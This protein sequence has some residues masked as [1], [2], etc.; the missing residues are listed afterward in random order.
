MCQNSLCK[1]AGKVV[2]ISEK[3]RIVLEFRKTDKK[4]EIS[5]IIPAYNRKEILK[6]TLSF[7]FNQTCPSNNYEII[8]VDDGS[9]DN[10]G[11]MIR[12][13][14]PPCNLKYIYW[15]RENAYV[16]G[17]K[18]NRAGPARNIGA[19]FAQADIL[20]FLDS[21]SIAAPELLEEHIRAHSCGNDIVLG[22]R[23]R[24]LE[25]DDNK[26][27]E[28]TDFNDINASG[29]D[30]RQPFFEIYDFDVSSCPT[31]WV[32]FFSHN[33][34]I[35]R[36]HF[37]RA[38]GFC[39]DFVYW[40][41][42]DEE[43]GYRLYKK[44][45]K[46]TLN[47][48]AKTIHQHHA[49]E[50][51][52]EEIRGKGCKENTEIFY[53]KHNDVNIFYRHL[54][55]LHYPMKAGGACNNNCMVCSDIGNKAGFKSAE[56][57]KHLIDKAKKRNLPI[58]L[59]GGEVPIRKDFFEILE[60][61]KKTG[62]EKVRLRTNGRIFSYNQFVKRVLDYGIRDFIIP[63][64]GHTATLHDSMTG[65]SGWNR[66]THTHEKNDGS[67]DQTITGI[68]NLLKS[69]ARVT[70]NVVLI[71]KN[72][73]FFDQIIAY[74]N[75]VGVAHFMITFNPSADT[76]FS[77]TIE[78]IKKK[79]TQT[80]VI[81][82]NPFFDIGNIEEY[83]ENII[84][85]HVI[86][87][88][89]FDLSKLKKPFSIEFDN[90]NAI[91]VED[92]FKALFISPSYQPHWSQGEP[93]GLASL[94]SYLKKYAGVSSSILD[95]NISDMDEEEIIRYVKSY[96]PRLIG[97]TAIT[98][99]VLDAYRIGRMLKKAFPHI[100][101]VYG[102]V[103]PT[104]MP[105]EPFEK[106]D[107]DSIIIGEGEETLLELVRALEKGSSLEGIKG[108]AYRADNDRIVVNEPRPFIQDLSTLPLPEYKML[109]FDK[110]N[111]DIHVT[112]HKREPAAEVM[113]S[114]G[115]TGN[116]V[117]C[118]SPAL[119]KR[120]VRFRP[121]D[122]I[123]EELDLL[124]N[125]MGI[126]AIHFHD[127]NFLLDYKRVIDLCRKIKE[128]KLDFR[129]I[130]LARTDTVV[131]HPEILKDMKNVG[132]VG[133][134]I[135]VE[136]ADENVL[137]KLN[138]SQDISTIRKA[139][140]LLKES[141][142]FPIYLIMCYSLGE[143]IE[144]PYKSA[145]LYYELKSG[146]PAGEELPIEEKREQHDEV[147]ASHMAR[148]SPGAEFYDI[149]SKEG[150]LLC[151]DWN[152]HFEE[153]IN[154]I[155]KEFLNDIPATTSVLKGRNLSEFILKYSTNIQFYAD[156]NFYISRPVISEHFGGMDNYLKF[157]ELVHGCCDGR[158][159]VLE[160]SEHLASNGKKSNITMVS[161][162]VAMLSVLGLVRSIRNAKNSEIDNSIL[163]KQKISESREKYESIKDTLFRSFDITQITDLIKGNMDILGL[164]DGERAYTGPQRIE[165]HPTNKC[166][167][168]CICCWQYSPLIKNEK[169]KQELR[170]HVMPFRKMKETVDEIYRI[171]GTREILVSGG[172][173]PLLYPELF[174]L[175]KYIKSKGFFCSLNT[176]FTLIGKKE[177][178]ML[179]ESG[180]DSITASI[181]AGDART[182]SMLHPN[183][184][185][186][187]FKKIRNSMKFFKKRKVELGISKPRIFTYNVISNMNY[188]EIEAMLEFGMEVGA[189]K[190]MFTIMDSNTPETKCLLLPEKNRK[191]L[192]KICERL[193]ENP[194]YNQIIDWP[195]FS[196]FLRRIS[197]N[198][199][200]EG[201]YEKGFI[202]KI[203]CFTGWLFAEFFA[204]GNVS[205][206]CK[207]DRTP[208]GN[209][210]KNRFSDIWNSSNQGDFR[211]RGLNKQQNGEY[212]TDVIYCDRV[213]D[214][215][216]DINTFMKKIIGTNLKDMVLLNHVN[217]I[218][219]G[220]VLEIRLNESNSRNFPEAV[221][222]FGS[223]G[224]KKINISLRDLRPGLSH[225][226][227]A[228]IKEAMYAAKKNNLE[229]RF[230][231]EKTLLTLLSNFD[232]FCP[233]EVS[234]YIINNCNS[235]CL[236]CWDHSPLLK[237]RSGTWQ[238]AKMDFSFFKK[239]VDELSELGT[240]RINILGDGEPLLHPEIGEMIKYAKSKDL[241]ISIFTNGTMLDN[242]KDTINLVDYLLINVSAAKPETYSEIHTN[243]SSG[244]FEKVIE[245]I[246]RLSGKMRID[247]VN[248]ITK[249]NINEVEEMIKLAG[250]IGAQNVTIKLISSNRVTGETLPIK[251]LLPSKSKIRTLQK[252][253]KKLLDI[254][255]VHGIGL[256]F[257][258]FQDKELC[259]KLDLDKT[260]IKKT[261]CFSRNV[262]IDINGNLFPCAFI[263]LRFGNLKEKKISYF[264]KDFK[265]FFE[266][267]NSQDFEKSPVFGACRKICIFDS[268]QREKFRELSGYLDNWNG[269][270]DA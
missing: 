2:K 29:L 135:G 5:V 214:N 4:P 242:I 247:I 199:A 244:D 102:G 118:A 106:G 252:N 133:V 45:L 164:L 27:L 157:M 92:E 23:K 6:T 154:F 201:K 49:P 225:D 75:A 91:E 220:G 264:K 126:R 155:P 115:C 88:E 47:K 12:S 117:Y 204:D 215:L 153:R 32:F 99:Q 116:C 143:T 211:K 124:V 39:E 186:K 110:Y 178:E 35:K 137:R 257:Q 127:D 113:T 166:N 150:I 131:Q 175:L 146:K 64:Y 8:I 161:S 181:W 213:C 190:V 121:I 203:P 50:Y 189:D 44:G 197:G 179:I 65:V 148:P 34:S 123:I 90:E 105:R 96:S 255:K 66:G 18:G 114:R 108:L 3:I 1:S 74:L 185:E 145:R 241:Q 72:Y 246:K 79:Y 168:N 80:R 169:Q 210:L 7:L 69:G 249:N 144:T 151:R 188:K 226:A 119:Y 9:T 100:H 48:N 184:T 208:V 268:E 141:G 37:L 171:G 266:N 152:D 30:D 63:I 38:G 262:K 97:L 61:A 13:L 193:K 269:D 180:V 205:S 77:K 243:F 183:K 163:V 36:D 67:F 238:N 251:Y 202:E 22:Y 206:C 177:V 132:C 198:Y 174:R 84:R 81:L 68:T 42:E 10:T 76:N 170:G 125:K 236:F 31:P 231:S 11:E 33:V 234:F 227:I 200:T 41:F 237:K 25:K 86:S 221:S 140:Q 21:D 43:L 70:A 256:Y 55:P 156:F 259:G 19:K 195:H 250:K 207:S 28:K 232:Y 147:F 103:H 173:E 229:L 165:I 78:K 254:A 209:I 159:S 17:E 222:L 191:E 73:E 217:S 134:E 235:D 16:Y 263:P 129:W 160:I 196:M 270:L 149:A 82:R 111:C 142:I 130:C 24:M 128:R 136:C 51:V 94:V 258:Y 224:I 40:A 71:E 239:I 240:T 182:Y 54:F 20:L 218:R 212:F 104:I 228:F 107:A 85:D 230:D 122:N 46:F 83:N 139:N 95:L 56:E 260:R 15:P 89:I 265:R 138:K 219:R 261:L 52:N 253:K 172:G 59:C 53:K 112:E 248:V 101:I 267:I 162:A 26:S 14:D 233:E 98:K 109:D 58:L 176:N 57:I 62:P 93:T 194:E 167:N 216:G 120:I 187:D 158:M 192:Q 245:I 60:H 87:P 223:L